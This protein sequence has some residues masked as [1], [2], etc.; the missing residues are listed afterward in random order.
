MANCPWRRNGG[1]RYS[2]S[3]DEKL[4]RTFL[5]PEKNLNSTGSTN[6]CILPPKVSRNFIAEFPPIK[7]ELQTP[8]N[9]PCV[10]FMDENLTKDHEKRKIPEHV[11]QRWRKAAIWVTVICIVVSLIITIASFQSAGA[12]DS[13]S[14]LALAFDAANALVCSSVVLW[15][16][17]NPKNGSLGYKRERIAC[18]VF[19]VSFILSGALTT[20]L[21]IK[22]LVEKE[23]A[24]KTFCIAVV[25]SVGC[26][27]Y[28]ILAV[29]QCYIS[30]KLHSSAM[31]GSSLDSGLSAAL[32]VGLLIGDCTYVLAH[33]DLWYLDH[34]MAILISLISML[35][36][37]QIL[38]EVLVYKALP[39]D[40][41]T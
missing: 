34:S 9:K 22:R 23:H 28:S 26:I 35:C 2:D 3:E 18:V 24:I 4:S 27:L 11:R 33:T 31:L 16:F 40:M 38:V 6:H 21:S 29:L 19:A 30:K 20:G 32:M 8:G 41:L 36:G 5:D 13:S 37:A 39:M 15:R 12:Y 14:A 7:D 1:N 10:S 25:L 17:K